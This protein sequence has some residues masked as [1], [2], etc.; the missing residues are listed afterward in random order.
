MPICDAILCRNVLIY[1]D[2]DTVRAVVAALLSRLRPDGLLVVG[3][4]ESLL[5]FG[6]AVSCEEHDGVFCYRKIP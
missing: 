4:S 6:S 5:R 1:F 2:D 3:V